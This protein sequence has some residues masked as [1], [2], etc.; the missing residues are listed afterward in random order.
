LNVVVTHLKIIIFISMPIFV[1]GPTGLVKSSMGY[2]ILAVNP[3][4]GWPDLARMC[5]LF[6]DKMFENLRTSF[7]KEPL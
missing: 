4:W 5:K 3:L 6:D 2:S 7:L 1:C